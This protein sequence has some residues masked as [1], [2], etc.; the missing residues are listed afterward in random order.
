MTSQSEI[1][2]PGK[3]M[4]KACLV[5]RTG[6]TI[7]T[8]PKTTK[9]SM[10]DRST[11]AAASTR[12]PIQYMICRAMGLGGHQEDRQYAR[13]HQGDSSPIRPGIGSQEAGE[14]NA[15]IRRRRVDRSGVVYLLGNG[16]G[17]IKTR[18]GGHRRNVI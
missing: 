14:V 7:S 17:R 5:Q 8:I 4:G 3:P 2:T 10:K 11:A 12:I 9:P 6:G 1:K 18:T 15:G 16:Q 13:G